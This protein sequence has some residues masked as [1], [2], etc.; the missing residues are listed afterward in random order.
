MKKFA[1][2]VATFIGL[3]L[4]VALFSPNTPETMAE[5][6]TAADSASVR[7]REARD[8]IAVARVRVKARLK[9]PESAQFGEIVVRNNVVCGTVN[10]KNPFGG[11]T[12]PEL[13][14]AFGTLVYFDS[15]LKS[16]TPDE[17]KLPREMRATCT[18]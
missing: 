18:G 7:E 1:L 10:S 6:R 3:V 15:D 11:Y 9:D 16:L 8:M 2:G 17:A 4:V 13:F 14:Y 5:A 12:G